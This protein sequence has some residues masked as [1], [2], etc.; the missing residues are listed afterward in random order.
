[1]RAI[2]RF[3]QARSLAAQGDVSTIQPWMTIHYVSL[4]YAVPES[5][6]I[7]RLSITD[8]RPVTHIS[9]RSIAVR[10]NRSLDGLIRDLQTAIKEYRKQ[11]P[12]HVSY[13]NLHTSTLLALERSMT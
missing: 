3:Q 8:S 1:V 13:S 6:L 9:L 10:Y 5:Y 7:E 2:Q 12:H 11:S 4:A